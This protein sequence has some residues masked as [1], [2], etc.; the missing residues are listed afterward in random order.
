MSQHPGSNITPKKTAES[1][2]NRV[3]FGTRAKE[4]I[5]LQVTRE[6]AAY[7]YDAALMDNLS[8]EK[9]VKHPHAR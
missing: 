6:L 8:I 5:F 3:F 7:G 2:S 9:G 1:L 4:D